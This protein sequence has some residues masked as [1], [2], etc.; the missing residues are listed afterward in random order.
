MLVLG[1]GSAAGGIY[2]S[3][4]RAEFVA[5]EMGSSEPS[6]TSVPGYLMRVAP[7]GTCTQVCMP[8]IIKNS[9]NKYFVIPRDKGTAKLVE[10]L[11]S[12]QKVLC[13]IPSTMKPGTE[14]HTGDPSTWRWKGSEVQAHPWLQREFAFTLGSKELHLKN[15]KYNKTLGENWGLPRAKEGVGNKQDWQQEGKPCL[16]V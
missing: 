1:H 12:I 11:P 7:V 13:L 6:V 5:P 15:R 16:P 10:C 3:C 8:P 4:R 2:C 9:K 14:E